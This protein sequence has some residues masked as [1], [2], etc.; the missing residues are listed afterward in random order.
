MD[1]CPVS[2]HFI[3]P[4]RAKIIATLGPACDDMDAIKALKRAG[5]SVIRLNMSHGDHDSHRERIRKIRQASEELGQAIGIIVDLQGPKLRIG[6]LE[7]QKPVQLAPNSTIGLKSSDKPGNAKTLTTDNPQLLAALQPGSEVLLS[8]GLIRLEVI[9]KK[10]TKEALCRVIHGGMLTENKGINVPRLP[11]HFD[12]LTEKDKADVSFAMAEKVDFLA[13]SFVR[14]GQDLA[15][16]KAYIREYCHCEPPPIIAK[17]EKP[18]ALED[19]DRILEEAFALMVARGDLG[20]ELSPEQVPVVQKQLIEKANLAE[21]P[22]IVAT[23]MLESM[24]HS[25]YPTR[26][27]VSDV[28][29]A[30]FDGA[31]VLML[32]GETAMGDHPL[33]VVEMMSRVIVESEKHYQ[34]LRSV[35][36]NYEASY[37][38]SPHFHHAIA[39]AAFYASTKANASALV[40]LSHSGRMA[41]RLS[42]LKPPQPIIALTPSREVCNRMTLLWGVVPLYVPYGATST[43]TFHLGEF[44]I[45]CRK[46]LKAG[47]DVLYCA[48]ATSVPG[49]SNMLQFLTLGEVNHA[50]GEV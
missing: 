11:M 27:E 9:E 22:I 17:I 38:R 45:L 23:Q 26:A 44:E 15:D 16:L 40:V 6:K 29:N 12:A 13:L 31:D 39:H 32:S 36:P 4:G 49:A 35:A 46:I 43:E 48:G 3:A 37:V 2:A 7:G 41:Q 14:S 50:V 21:K 25:D 1:R 5:V 42:K 8:D 34:S 30:V 24:I 10:S 28:A 19:L 33:T 20:V 18:Q 47:D